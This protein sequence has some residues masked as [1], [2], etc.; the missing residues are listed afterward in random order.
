MSV[1]AGVAGWLAHPSSKVAI[2]LVCAGVL[3]LLL[4]A[5]LPERLYWTGDAVQGVNN[6]GIV[7]YQVDG[8]EWTVNDP[9]PVPAQDTPVTVYVDPDEPSH[10]LLQGPGRWI[11]GVFVLV[12]FVAAALL[13][14]LAASRRAVGRRRRVG[15]DPDPDWVRRHLDSTRHP[16][17]RP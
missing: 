2:A 14:A 1:R 11:D 12:W 9:G 3:V 10:A 13:V 8:R 5:Q 16:P 4:L 17:Q 7:Y 15:E 6:G